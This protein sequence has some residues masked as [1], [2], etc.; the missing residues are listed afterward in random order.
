MIPVHTMIL[1]LL[2]SNC[3]ELIAFLQFFFP[4]GVLSFGLSDTMGICIV[5]YKLFCNSRYESGEPTDNSIK[6][7]SRSCCLSFFFFSFSFTSLVAFMML[8]HFLGLLRM[9][10][11]WFSG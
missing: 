11:S 8:F 1:K 5:R 7:C 9:P 2:P 3:K 4:S 10:D 6:R